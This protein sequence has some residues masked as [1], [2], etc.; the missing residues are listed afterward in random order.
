MSP[1]TLNTRKSGSLP[2]PVE[3][4]GPAP[5]TLPRFSAWNRLMLYPLAVLAPGMGLT[6]G[7]LY[8]RQDDTDAKRFGRICLVLG[9][10][11]LL[12]RIGSQDGVGMS[13]PENLSQPFY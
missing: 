3:A 8:F 12:A 13:A 7:L 1:R 10:L 11:G 4:A 5:L 2:P 9:I 6:L